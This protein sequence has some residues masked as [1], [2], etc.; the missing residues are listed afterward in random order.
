MTQGQP[1]HDPMTSQV[2]SPSFQASWPATPPSASPQTALQ[3]VGFLWSSIGRIAT[4]VYC[5][6]WFIIALY[7]LSIVLTENDPRWL[8]LTATASGNV[9]A[10][11]LN[12]TYGELKRRLRKDLK[13][14]ILYLA[15]GAVLAGGVWRSLY[16][17]DPGVLTVTAALVLI[18]MM[19]AWVF[20]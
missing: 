1:T 19:F 17:D 2:A 6:T 12:M 9:F 4:V 20:N 7:S 16:F 13:A 10:Y 11:K 3:T 5:G 15:A 14:T 8:A 18:V